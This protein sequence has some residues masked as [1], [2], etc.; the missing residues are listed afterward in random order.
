[1]INTYIADCEEDSCDSFVE[2]QSQ[3]DQKADRRREISNSF[4][5]ISEKYYLDL[6]EK[7]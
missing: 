4:L 1:M 5:L 2:K 6:T 7:A 3:K